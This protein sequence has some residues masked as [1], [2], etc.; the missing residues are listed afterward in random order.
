MV[1]ALVSIV[2]DCATAR[3]EHLNIAWV[4][5][6]AI[7][8]AVVVSSNITAYNDYIKE[9]WLM[10]LNDVARSRK[11]VSVWRNG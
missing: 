8:M 2:I 9:R 1:S 7:L 10:S 4:E 11:R 6:F 3:T 5:G